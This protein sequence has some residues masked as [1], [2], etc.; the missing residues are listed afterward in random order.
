M[1]GIILTLTDDERDQRDK[2]LFEIQE[3]PL[4]LEQAVAEL[5]VLRKL[6]AAVKAGTRQTPKVRRVL[7]RFPTKSIQVVEK[8]EPERVQRLEP[9]DTERKL[10]YA[11]S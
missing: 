8:C 11:D 4:A 1:P 10:W 3:S 6:K 9:I 7:D 5:L 2:M